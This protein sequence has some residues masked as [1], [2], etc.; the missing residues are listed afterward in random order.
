VDRTFNWGSETTTEA[1]NEGCLTLL[2]LRGPYLALSGRSC[3]ES[4]NKFGLNLCARNL[5]LNL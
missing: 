1:K 3:T 2:T 4:K 5:I